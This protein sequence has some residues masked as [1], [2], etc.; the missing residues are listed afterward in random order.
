MK[1][2]TLLI[3]SA[4]SIIIAA[5]VTARS[6][7]RIVAQDAPRFFET[8]LSSY[9]KKKLRFGVVSHPSTTPTT[10]TRGQQLLLPPLRPVTNAAL[11]VRGGGG[12]GLALVLPEPLTAAK[13]FSRIGLVQGVRMISSPSAMNELY[14]FKSTGHRDWL[15]DCIGH[16]LICTFIFMHC[17]LDRNGLDA[18]HAMAYSLIGWLLFTIRQVLNDKQGALAVGYKKE[19][20]AAGMLLHAITIYT[21]FFAN[22]GHDHALLANVMVK[23][24]AVS[25]SF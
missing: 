6:T 23:V 1:I 2:F 13:W 24:E 9:Q 21:V 4:W 19:G 17:L 10:L 20:F 15:A 14:G 8:A 7:T 18:N 12:G 22:V 5:A 11:L 25:Y 3:I 16:G